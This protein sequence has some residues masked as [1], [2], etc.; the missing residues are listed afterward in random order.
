MLHSPSN[1]DEKK[2]F[3]RVYEQR[4]KFRY[5]IKKGVQGKN[6]IIRDLSSCAIKK[7]YGYNIIN[8][9][10]KTDEKTLHE[11]IDIVYIPI[12]RRMELST[13]TLLTICIQPIDCIV[14]EKMLKMR[15]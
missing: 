1:F 4:D 13:V 9:E 3:L 7:I 2:L 11:P 14:L 6:K 15:V 10:V 5:V 8:A 12:K